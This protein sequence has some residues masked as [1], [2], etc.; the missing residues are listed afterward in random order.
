MNYNDQFQYFSNLLTKQILHYNWSQLCLSVFVCLLFYVIFWFLL[1]YK[2]AVENN[3]EDHE[4]RS[5]RPGSE[6][7]LYLLLA[8]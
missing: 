5:D 8:L 3:D 2:E 6:S 4:T 1:L 7:L